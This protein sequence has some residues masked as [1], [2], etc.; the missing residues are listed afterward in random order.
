MLEERTTVIIKGN[1]SGMAT[2]ITEM[3]KIK[4]IELMTARA[5]LLERFFDTKVNVR[6]Y[7]RLPC[8]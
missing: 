8:C 6:K 4:P 5:F 7:S 2:T 3:A 1:P